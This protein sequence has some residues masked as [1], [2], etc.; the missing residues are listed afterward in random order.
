[1]PTSSAASTPA[2]ACAADVGLDWGD[3]HHAVSLAAAGTHTVERTTLD[4]TPEALAAWASARR[5][6]FPDGNIA[7]C[8]EQARGPLRYAVQAYEHRVLY[9]INPN[10]LARCRAARSPSHRKN[11]PGGVGHRPPPVRR[12]AGGEL[13]QRHCPRHAAERPN[14]V[15]GPS[16]VERSEIDAAELA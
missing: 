8:L 11:D 14:R 2:L 7:V 3:E 13:L 4:Q 12:R 5:T 10:S 1:M 15:L 9:P 16:A 6:R